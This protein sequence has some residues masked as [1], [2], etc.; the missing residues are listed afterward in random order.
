MLHNPNCIANFN[1]SAKAF[2]S[3]WKLGNRLVGFASYMFKCINVVIHE[4]L[5]HLKNT[6]TQQRIQV[7]TC[8]LRRS[9]FP[10]AAT[11][12]H[13]FVSRLSKQRT[14]FCAKPKK[15]YRKQNNGNSCLKQHAMPS[16]HRCLAS[17]RSHIRPI[18]PF[19]NQAL[20]LNLAAVHIFIQSS[21]FHLHHVM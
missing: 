5:I 6:H 2:Q 9:T 11:I 13:L 10:F 19:P 14:N 8:E 17:L 1:S 4:H 16:I 21:P 3:I 18:Y 15:M 7:P 20:H 12:H